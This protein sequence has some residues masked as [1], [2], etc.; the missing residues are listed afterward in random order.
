MAQLNQT[1]SV[2]G[3]TLSNLDSDLVITLDSHP[4]VQISSIQADT[5]TYR[6]IGNVTQDTTYNL[7]LTFTYKQKYRCVVPMTFNHKVGSLTIEVDPNTISGVNGDEFTLAALLDH[8]G[9][10]IPLNSDGVT[11]SLSA[12]DAVQ[13]VDGSVGSSSLKLKIIKDASADETSTVT[14]TAK[15]G[16]LTATDD[17]TATVKANVVSPTLQDMQTPLTMNL[18]E[19]KALSFKVMLSGTDITSSITDIVATN[20]V[21]DK[22]EFVKLSNT[23]WG[24]KSVK[25][26]PSAQTTAQG[27]FN[28]KVTYQSKDYVIAGN[29]DL[30][31]NA[32]DGSIPTNRFDVTFV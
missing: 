20:D 23:S 14:I 5:I 27:Q 13:L 22:F 8:D 3:Q 15:L 28:V 2:N 9:S 26:D 11:I 18:W 12:S 4:A 7:N 19:S 21:S 17:V 10:A 30:I 31:T 16:N 32:N 6:F 25:S 29:V 1:L 24:Y